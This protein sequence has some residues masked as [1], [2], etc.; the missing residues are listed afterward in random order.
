M[1]EHNANR[2]TL[3]ILA[4]I[5]AFIIISG[6]YFEMSTGNDMTVIDGIK[7]HPTLFLIIFLLLLV[8]CYTTSHIIYKRVD[9]FNECNSVEAFQSW[10]TLFIYWLIILTCWLPYLII[11]FPASSMGWD[12]HWQ[13]LQGMGVVPL[14]NHHPVLGSLI[15]G[16]LYKIGYVF[17][18]AYG[19]LFFTGLFQVTLMSF[20]MA[21]GIFTLRRIG[22][23]RKVVW[24]LIAFIC[25]N[26]VFSGHAV[27]L[28]KDSIYASLVVILLALCLNF[29]IDKNRLF[30]YILIGVVG[31]LATM[32]RSEGIVIVLLLYL[33]L[34]VNVLRNKK[35]EGFWKLIISFASVLVLFI[36][37]K[38]GVRVS[39]I[40]A[41]STARE[42]MT[43]FSA[44][45]IN[46]IKK[47]PT[48]ISEQ[49]MEILHRSYDDLDEA[50]MKYDETVRD[51]IKTKDMG[52][53]DTVEYLKTW[54]QIGTRH[55]GD[56]FDS[57]LRGTDGYWW[58]LK[59]PNRMFKDS[60]LIRSSTPL[61]A[62]E[63]DFANTIIRDVKVMEHKWLKSTY[64]AYG[65][66]MD[67]TIGEL[68]LENNPDLEGIYYVK[69]SFPNT[70]NSLNEFLDQLKELPLFQ[71]IF[72]PG[73]Y[74]VV[75]LLSLGYLF[76]RRRGIFWQCIPIMVIMI[77]NML[78]PINGY[79]RY[80][81]PV[82]LSSVLMIGLC[83]TGRDISSH[84]EE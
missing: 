31:F 37:F 60:N 70:R 48:D 19:G 8:A 51:P 54:F 7:S 41:T 15:Y 24:C 71:L 21:Y 12:Y 17:G 53:E 50:V 33:P 39:G 79:M 4:V 83:F 38:I 22:A 57:F 45:I 35:K 67:R 82:A 23:N 55:I 11:C 10:K 44:Q 72:V 77:I 59:P 52:F 78:S 62:P 25:I 34:V 63:H 47:Y 66:E 76:I 1:K 27:W 49:E 13:L 18:G 58:M 42:S 30:Y 84:G 14:S 2:I 29:R 73:S 28:I 68:V 64:D 69:S 43:L 9:Q 5:L 75:S 81:L 20:A 16:L 3:L 74:F 80:F 26:P 56:Y 40:P 32:Y 36:S 46:C 65:I 61:F 6:S